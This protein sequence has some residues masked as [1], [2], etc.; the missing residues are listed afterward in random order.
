MRSEGYS[1]RFVCLCVCVSVCVSMRSAF[2][3]PAHQLAVRMR[4]NNMPIII[5]MAQATSHAPCAS[6]CTCAEGLH[7]SAFHYCS[8]GSCTHIC[9]NLAFRFG[10]ESSSYSVIESEGVV[11]VCLTADRGDGSEVYTVTLSYINVTTQGT[12]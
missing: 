4:I 7:F 11:S 8:N 12:R 2:R 9:L 5:I 1:S 6:N 10:F 3:G